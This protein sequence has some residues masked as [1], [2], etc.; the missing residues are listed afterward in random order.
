M[1]STAPP[2]PSADRAPTVSYRDLVNEQFGRVSD[3]FVAVEK[4]I[5][6]ADADLTAYKLTANEFRGTLSDQAARLATKDDLDQVRAS[7]EIQRLRVD[8]AE[9]TSANMQGKMW[10]LAA[11]FAVLQVVI[12]IAQRFLK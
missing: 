1:P 3:K 8:K 12:N 5:D 6:K 4:A 9:N 11:V 7:I 10:M 2:L